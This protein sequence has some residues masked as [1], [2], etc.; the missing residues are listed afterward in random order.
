MNVLSPEYNTAYLEPT[1][2]NDGSFIAYPASN[3]Y[4]G[5][6]YVA[7]DGSPGPAAWAKTYVY[8]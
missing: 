3:H 6:V 4:V 1:S 7:L 8:L 2:I 5:W